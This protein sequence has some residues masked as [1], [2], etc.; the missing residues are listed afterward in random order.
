MANSGDRLMKLTDLHCHI[1]PRIDDGAKDLAASLALLQ[2]HKQQNIKRIAF[3]PH[4]N[5]EKYTI[6]EFLNVRSR[7]AQ[8]L[9][10]ALQRAGQR[11]PAKLGAEVY[12]SPQ[13]LHQD[14]APL[15]LYGTPYILVELPT[16]YKPTGVRD[17]LYELQLCGYTPILAH[18]ERYPYFMQE[19]DMVVELAEAGVVMQI[20]ASSLLRE[21]KRARKLMQMIRYNLVHIIA[22]DTHSVHRRPSRMAEAFEVVKTR[23]GVDTARRLESNAST[24][25]KGKVL[26]LEEP[27]APKRFL[28]GW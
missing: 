8:T 6:R 24:I 3:T 25:F 13:L 7:S 15:C 12:F 4:F 23:L 1:L 11:F 17:T 14:V 5:F 21:V 20:N 10:K 27:T 26:Y 16:M 22:S 2:E 9:V 19:P 18:I 28:T